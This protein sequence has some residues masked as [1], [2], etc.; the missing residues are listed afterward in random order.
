L[1]NAKNVFF[2]PEP[3]FGSFTKEPKDEP[4]GHS[5]NK[6]QLEAR[7]SRERLFGG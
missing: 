3:G 2:L 7:K 4:L 1:K 6:T 5:K